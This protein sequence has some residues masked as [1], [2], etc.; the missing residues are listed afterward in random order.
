[1]KAIEFETQVRNG[2]IELPEKFKD[3]LTGS[4]RVILLI[5][6]PSGKPDA[7]EELMA[8]PIKVENFKPLTREEIYEG[9]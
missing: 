5:E 8:N 9:R 6:E 1:M 4:V 3:E 7:L 2:R